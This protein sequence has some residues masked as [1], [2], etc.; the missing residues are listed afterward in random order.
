MN[1]QTKDISKLPKWAR[2]YID[3]LENH[4]KESRRALD[5]YLDDQKKSPIYTNTLV[6]D[7]TPPTIRTR[8][9][10][11]T[12]GIHIDYAGIKCN[13]ALGIDEDN[14]QIFF[15]AKPNKKVFLSPVASNCIKLV[16]V[17][18]QK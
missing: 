12:Q 10:Q 1:N 13:I 17:D 15:E 5:D 14:I 9:I 3:S 7:N 18:R 8:Y 6:C 2:E 11:D 4:L 16:S